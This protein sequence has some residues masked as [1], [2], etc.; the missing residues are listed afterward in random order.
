VTGKSRIHGFGVFAKVSH[1][2]GDMVCLFIFHCKASVWHYADFENHLFISIFGCR[3]WLRGESYSPVVVLGKPVWT[4]ER[5]P[6]LTRSTSQH[7]SAK[8]NQRRIVF[9]FCKEL[10]CLVGRTFSNIT[11][12]ISN[13]YGDI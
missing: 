5:V 9:L 7:C 2:A 10:K 11:V 3:S 8:H 6:C 12:E 4:L 1:K 13:K